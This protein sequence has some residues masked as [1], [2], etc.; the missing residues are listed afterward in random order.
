MTGGI[1]RPVLPSL[2]VNALENTNATL[3]TA[4]INYVFQE[5]TFWQHHATLSLSYLLYSASYFGSAHNPDK[6]MYMVRLNICKQ[7]LDFEVIL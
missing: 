5:N 6:R 7:K 4:H 3:T 2:Y 1:T